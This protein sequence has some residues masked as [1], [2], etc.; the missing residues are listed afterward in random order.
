MPTPVPESELEDYVSEYVFGSR[1]MRASGLP[2]AAKTTELRPDATKP[3]P[4]KLGEEGKE[5]HYTNGINIESKPEVE[6]YEGSQR[7]EP[8]YGC[9]LSGA[10]SVIAQIRDAVAI[11]DSPRGCAFTCL[12]MNIGTASLLGRE[13]PAVPNLLCTNMGDRDAVFGSEMRLEET[14][15]SIDRRLSPKAIFIITSC[16]SG[17]I[18]NDMSGMVERLRGKGIAIITVATDGVM[19]GDFYAGMESAY[20][21]VAEH[22]IDERVEPVG[23]MVNI[24][25]EQNLSTVADRN[26]LEIERMLRDI[27]IRVNCRFVRNTTVDQL[28]SFRL[29]SLSIPLSDAP[30]VMALASFFKSRFNMDTA[31]FILPYAFRQTEAFLRGVAGRFHKGIDAEK[32]IKQA[33]AEYALGIARLKPEYS[34]KKVIISSHT[35]NVDWLI[36]TL[37]DLDADIRKVCLFGTPYYR[38]EFSS[39]YDGDNVAIEYGCTTERFEREVE[40]IRPDLVLA[41]SEPKSAVAGVQYGVFPAN[42][43]QGFFSGLDYARRWAINFRV[44]FTEGWRNDRRKFAGTL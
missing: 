38:S 8:A 3:A 24:I 17:I 10:Y 25:G 12:C 40:A 21:I 16:P 14:V 31:G 42:P 27:G 43:A 15:L 18:G 28:R 26:F 44:P 35:N 1:P 7:R 5:T 22:F 30:D 9:A 29:A 4:P 23:D 20:R 11:M 13:E 2:T 41:N 19:G 32:V 37:L 39:V 6:S 36:A 33:G 34:G